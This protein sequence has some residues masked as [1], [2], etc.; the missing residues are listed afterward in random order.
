LKL[1]Y[2]EVPLLIYR[3]EAGSK[4]SLNFYKQF[5]ASPA[6]VIIGLQSAVFLPFFNLETIVVYDYKHRGHFSINQHPYYSTTKVAAIW[7][8]LTNCQLVLTAILPDID[9]IKVSEEYLKSVPIN[10]KKS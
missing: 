5:I 7:S 4:D 9:L 10:D 2:P 3:R 6:A 1:N 8:K